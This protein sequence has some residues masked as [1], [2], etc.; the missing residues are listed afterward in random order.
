MTIQSNLRTYTK[1]E[2]NLYLVGLAGQNLL[3]GI[4]AALAYYY[5]FTLLIPAMAVSVILTVNQIWDALKDPL[6]GNLMDRTRSKWGKARPYVLFSPLPL[7]IFLVLC[8]SNAIFD[9]SQGM[10]AP[11]S[12]GIVCWAFLSYFLFGLAFTAGD[13]PLHS[14]PNLMTEDEHDRTKL[15]SLKMIAQ[16]VGMLGIAVQPLALQAGTMLAKS[17]SSVQQTEQRGFLLVAGLLVPLG[18][19]AFQLAG[20]FARERV[21][22]PK[23]VNSIKENL[24][25]MWR[26]RPFRAVLLSGLLASPKAVEMVGTMPLYTYYYANKD[27]GKIIL[28]SVL[29]GG[30]SFLGKII[31]SR[32]TPNLTQKFE[33]S[34]LFIW[35]NIAS[36]LPML[37]IYLLFCGAPT[38]MADSLQLVLTSLCYTAGGT[39]SAIQSIVANLFTSDAVDYEEWNSGVRPDG[40]FVS[41]QTITVKLSTGI[42]SLI[43]GVVYALS[44]FSGQRIADLNTF[45]E[46]GGVAKTSAVFAGDM[47]M[48]FFLATIPSVVGA[49]LCVLPMLRYP[50]SDKRHSELLRELNERRHGKS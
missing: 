13:I 24:L 29:I 4:S 44:G 17:G 41:G 28:F 35:G 19:A 25:L 38:K 7:G 50:L 22:L 10:V 12:L 36:A 48:L 2:R 5:Q 8:F 49:L 45:I 27:P 40:V 30:G 20:I 23:K 11:R 14:L 39:L 26:N 21:S 1:R 46:A 9:P 33:K 6:M 43:G 3:Y 32:L 37:L 16:L 18:V 47:R 15:I 42:S 31:A 34:K